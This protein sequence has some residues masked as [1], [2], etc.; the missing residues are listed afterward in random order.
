MI[1]WY[2]G[3]NVFAL[4]KEQQAGLRFN[5]PRV[6]AQQQIFDGNTRGLDHQGVHDLY[7]RAFGDKQRA[8]QARTSFL[9]QFVKQQCA[10]AS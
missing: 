8:E 3:I 1:Y 7:L 2:R 9:E 5:L 4:T 10:A 6:K